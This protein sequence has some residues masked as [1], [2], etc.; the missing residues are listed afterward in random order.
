MRKQTR[1][2]LL[3]IDLAVFITSAIVLLALGY[4]DKISHTDLLSK[5]GLFISMSVAITFIVM[6]WYAVKIMTSGRLGR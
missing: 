2:I 1:K 6:M 5:Y 3:T 4:S